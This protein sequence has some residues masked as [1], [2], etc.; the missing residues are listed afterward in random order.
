MNPSSSTTDGATAAS[1]ARATPALMGARGV[2]DGAGPRAPGVAAAAAAKE[3]IDTIAGEF[4][5]DAV[6]SRG[7][8]TIS[9]AAAMASTTSPGRARDRSMSIILGG[10]GGIAEAPEAAPEEETDEIS[11]CASA[12]AA[13]GDIFG[14]PLITIS[15]ILLCSSAARL[16]SS[17]SSR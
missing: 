13:A 10:G 3:S 14:F 11:G 1:M 16:N 6:G 7:W 2:R 9:A 4:V 17:V 8:S 15:S 5:I 12:A